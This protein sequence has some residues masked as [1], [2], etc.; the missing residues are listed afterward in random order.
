MSNLPLALS[1][2]VGREHDLAAVNALLRRS[3]LLTLA[4]SGGVGK[5]RLALE[6]GIDLLDASNNGVWF[7]DL[8]PLSDP[9]LVI[10]TIASTLSVREQGERPLLDALL[11]YLRPRQLFL[12]LDNCEHLVEEVARIADAILR[13]APQVRLLATSREPLRIGGEYVYRVPSLDVPK[14]AITV[15]NALQYG[16][17]ALFVE[18]ARASD[19]TFKLTEESAP[20]VGEICRRLDGIALAI[21]LAAARVKV[22]TPRQ[23]A[24]KLDERFRVLTGGSRTALP[25]QQTM[26]ALID[27]SYDLLTPREQLLFARLGIFKGG[28]GYDAVMNVCGAGLDAV[29]SLDLLGS[30]TDKSLV[31]ADIHGEHERYRLLESTAAY[32]LEKLCASGERKTLARRHAEY[33][34][35]QARAADERSGT[36]STISRVASAELELDNN[37]TALEWALTQGND[38]ALGGAIA[39]ALSALWKNT[40]LTVEGRYWIRLAL[41]RLNE[42]EHP[43]VAAALWDA[44]G[45]L[46]SGRRKHDMAKR[47]MQLYASVRDTRGA[48]RAQQNLAFALFQMGRLPEAAAAIEQALATSRARED[49]WNVANCLDTQA[50]IT[51]V[52]GDVRT[53]RE[54]YSQALAGFKAR[55][56]EWGTSIVLNNMSELEFADGH[57]DLALLAASEVLEVNALGKN[58]A[59]IAT[60]YANSAA[61]RIVLGDLTAA[62]ESAREGLR[63]ARQARYEPIITNALQHLALLAGLTGDARRGAQL[64]GYVNAQYVAL[65]M[66]RQP[67]EQWGYDNLVATLR[68]ALTTDEITRLGADGAAWSEDQAVAEALKV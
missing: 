64:L 26:R 61:Y 6:L 2:F 37:R 43:H 16:G 62:R 60:S 55:G 47:A 67:T 3:R 59:N 12:I 10:S 38:A 41:E 15:E 49:A 4:G 63:V 9:A 58:A 17:V 51:R 18:R 24:Q 14:G 8:A 7:I 50:H 34:R 27:W 30:L 31:V 11:L 28:F 52:R 54:L 25:R 53:A 35:N 20:I 32:A 1:G 40:D 36:G 13:T 33:F 46:S 39:G 19:A 44:L 57:P 45:L 29:D 23:L 65:G 21:E 22:L 68:E 42:A 5:T 66:Q 48:A 56:D